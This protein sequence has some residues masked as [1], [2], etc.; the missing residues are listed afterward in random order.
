MTPELTAFE[1]KF[2]FENIWRKKSRLCKKIQKYIRLSEFPKYVF[3]FIIRCSYK[4]KS[5]RELI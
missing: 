4:R 2:V 1:T 5:S 3:P